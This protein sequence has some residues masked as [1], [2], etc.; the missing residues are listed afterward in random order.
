MAR[1]YMFLL[2]ENQQGIL[3]QTDGTTDMKLT[4]PDQIMD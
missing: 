4:H 2:N 3:N 1:F